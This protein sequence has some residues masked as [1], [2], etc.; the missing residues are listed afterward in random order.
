MTT[1]LVEGQDVNLIADGDEVIVRKLVSVEKGMYF[2]CMGDEFERAKAEGREPI[3]I[4][5][6][7]EYVLAT[8]SDRL[9]Q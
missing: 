1:Q 6:R 9:N 2:V 3:C 5:F 4:G 8:E 7:S